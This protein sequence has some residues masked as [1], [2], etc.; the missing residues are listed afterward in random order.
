[1]AADFCEWKFDICSQ[2]NICYIVAELF[3]K[4][5][6]ESFASIQSNIL[7]HQVEADIFYLLDAGGS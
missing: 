2:Q 5:G 7:F 6:N 1:M 4:S 3:N